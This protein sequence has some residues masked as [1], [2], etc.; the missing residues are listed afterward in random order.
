MLYRACGRTDFQQGNAGGLFDGVHAKI[1]SLP[2][3]CELRSAHDYKGYCQSSVREERTLNP[4][5]IKPRDEFIKM[6]D[7]LNLP[8]PKKID[9]SLPANLRCGVPDELPLAPPANTAK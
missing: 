2:G 4:R 8:Y 1:F 7:N 5:F 3:N 6:M 9:A